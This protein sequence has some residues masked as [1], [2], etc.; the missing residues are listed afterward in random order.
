[1]SWQDD[2]SRDLVRSFGDRMAMFVRG[3]G[4]L[5]HFADHRVAAV[6]DPHDLV[7]EA[8]EPRQRLDESHRAGA[9]GTGI[10]ILQICHE[11]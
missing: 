7:A 4:L 6:L 9:G 3:E 10:G 8:L 11:E 5:Q 2:V 1:M